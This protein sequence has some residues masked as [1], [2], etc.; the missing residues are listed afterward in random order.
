[1]VVE[2]IRIGGSRDWHGDVVTKE[3]RHDVSDVIARTS[4]A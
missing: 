4:L 1:M 3:R 2:Y